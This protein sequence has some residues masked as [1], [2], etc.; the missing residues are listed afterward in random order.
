MVNFNLPNSSISQD[1]LGNILE[2]I[3]NN[4]ENISNLTNTYNTGISAIANKIT[5]CGV[6]TANN[7]SPNTMINNIGAIYANRYNQ[8]INDGRQGY[9]TQAQYNQ[10]GNDRYNAGINEGRVGWYN[11]TQYNNY[12][13][14][15][16][17]QGK[18]D[19]M[20]QG[21]CNICCVSDR[22]AF[23]GVS[24]KWIFVQYLVKD[25]GSYYTYKT[26]SCAGNPGSAG[27]RLPIPNVHQP[28]MFWT[29]SGNISCYST[30]YENNTKEIQ[31]D[32][33]SSYEIIQLYIVYKER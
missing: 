5:Q 9:Y 4:S 12:G 3:R 18:N 28:S 13:N 24:N 31:Q 17:N 20:A 8:G 1:E 33:N 15:R 19:G 10:Y 25:N 32:M 22:N 30:S 27:V 29:C 26:F 23:A 6:T 14:D 16:Y 21:T 11:Q 7:A 2:S